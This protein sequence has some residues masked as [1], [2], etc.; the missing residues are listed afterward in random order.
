MVEGD[1]DTAEFA[2]CPWDW[3]KEEI[4]KYMK[5]LLA[6]EVMEF[7]RNNLRRFG[8]LESWTQEQ[9][10]ESVNTIIGIAGK[11]SDMMNML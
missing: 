3:E 1:D 10:Q 5:V 6:D 2:E 7:A 8:Q 4:E 9:I 11:Y